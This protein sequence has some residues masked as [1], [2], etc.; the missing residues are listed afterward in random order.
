MALGRIEA[1]AVVMVGVRRTG[2]ERGAESTRKSRD[3]GGAAPFSLAR[4]PNARAIARWLPQV[5]QVLAA[6][7]ALPTPTDCLRPTGAA[8]APP[9]GGGGA[10]GGGGDATLLRAIEV[11]SRPASVALGEQERQIEVM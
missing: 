2:H 5:V 3:D 11:L 1:A 6:E 4:A 8:A 7:T 9:A 10:G